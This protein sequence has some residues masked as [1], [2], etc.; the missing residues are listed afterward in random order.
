MQNLP[1]VVLAGT[2]STYWFWVGAMVVRMRRKTR[3]DVGLV[4]QQ[5]FER[6][7]WL[8]YVPMVAAWIVVPWAT[9]EGSRA[10]PELPAFAVRE[11]AYVALRWIA[12]IVAVIA[13]LATIKVWGQMGSRWRM[14]VSVEGNAELIVDG[15]FARVR[16]PIYALSILLMLC[17]LVIVPTSPMLV[18]AVVHFVLNNVKAR[19]EERH[20]LRS[21][22][23][24]YARYLARTGRFVPRW[25][26]PAR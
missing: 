14:D 5:P 16:H 23:E 7:L 20:L 11:P 17:S 3:R 21:H 12:A 24:V 15:F 18:I 2:V 22:G 4:P 9:L 6:M 10:V 25:L 26:S 19:N 1:L 8:F 13:L